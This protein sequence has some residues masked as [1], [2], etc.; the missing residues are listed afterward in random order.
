MCYIIDKGILRGCQ[1]LPNVGASSLESADLIINLGFDILITNGID[2][3]MAD[4]LCAAGVEVVANATGEPRDAV[5]AYINNTL[6][7][8]VSPCHD[9]DSGDAA[10]EDI[11]NAFDRIEAQLMGAAD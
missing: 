11:D 2:M 4:R 1:N 6:L 8:A 9:D 3:D 10:E 7:G 5:D